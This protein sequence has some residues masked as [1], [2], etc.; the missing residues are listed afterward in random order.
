MLLL[1][2]RGTGESDRPASSSS[3]ELADYASDV[4]ELRRHL[5]LDRLDL[6]DG[7]ASALATLEDAVRF[8]EQRRLVDAGPSDRAAALELLVDLG[9]V[10]QALERYPSLTQLEDE[11]VMNAWSQ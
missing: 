11:G 4:E 3:Y 6:L 8:T 2:P 10:R 1:D 7:P 5:G 9:R